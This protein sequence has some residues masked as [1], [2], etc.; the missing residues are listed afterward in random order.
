MEV[1]GFVFF[2][3]FFCMPGEGNFKHRDEAPEVKCV[4]M[5]VTA[6]H[7]GF[8]VLVRVVLVHF[9]FYFWIYFFF[10]CFNWYRNEQ[11]R[12]DFSKKTKSSFLD[13]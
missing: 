1:L 7:A 5:E 13:V 8:F 3:F 4:R 6:G 10:L 9:Y 11:V 12:K 2:L